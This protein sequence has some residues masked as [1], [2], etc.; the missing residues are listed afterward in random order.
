VDTF[1]FG[2]AAIVTLSS[3]T[4]FC[5]RKLNLLFVAQGL[6]AGD[7]SELASLIGEVAEI[8]SSADSVSRSTDRLSISFYALVV[9]VAVATVAL[10]AVAAVALRRWRRQ[11]RRR[12]DDVAAYDSDSVSFYSSDD[13]EDDTRSVAGAMADSV[14]TEIEGPITVTSSSSH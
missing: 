13:N 7:S 3:S 4:S 5:S 14:T 8:G 12:L 1:F 10:V 6:S 11:R 2:I 9:W